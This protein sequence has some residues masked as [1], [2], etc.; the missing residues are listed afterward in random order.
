MWKKIILLTCISILSA[1]IGCDTNEVSPSEGDYFPLGGREWSYQR[2]LSGVDND[3]TVWDTLRL[4]VEGTV[5][6]EGKSYVRMGDPAG[7]GGKFVRVEGSK[8]YGRNHELYGNDFSAEYVFLDTEKSV[9]ES[10]EYIKDSGARKTEYVIKAVNA[11]HTLLGVTYKN[12]IEVNVNYYYKDNGVFQLSY[13]VVHYYAKGVG[14][15]YHYYP[16]PSLVYGDLSGLLMP[17]SA[18]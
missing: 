4:R 18:L 12:V 6:I 3:S 2:W 13:T 15:I 1:I 8:Y 16:Y 5:D 9:G 7:F 17:S 10:W 11:S 14:E